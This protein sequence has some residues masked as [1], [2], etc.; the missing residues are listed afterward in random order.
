MG[1]GIIYNFLSVHIVE[2]SSRVTEANATVISAPGSS[3]FS[4]LQGTRFPEW[5]FELLRT[6]K[7]K[8]MNYALNISWC[9]FA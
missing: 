9:K 7:I 4:E 5:I 6:K 3:V 8:I 1:R 2:Q